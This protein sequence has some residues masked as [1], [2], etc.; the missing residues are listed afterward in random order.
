MNKIINEKYGM[1]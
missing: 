1:N